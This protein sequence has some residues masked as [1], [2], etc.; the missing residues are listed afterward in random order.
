[1]KTDFDACCVDVPPVGSRV[2]VAGALTLELSVAGS[3][4]DGLSITLTGVS[5]ELWGTIG[6]LNSARF[7]K[8]Q[9]FHHDLPWFIIEVHHRQDSRSLR[10]WSQ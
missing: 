1:M 6:A 7:S 4:A 3:A 8:S 2:E 5:L 9:A 10:Q